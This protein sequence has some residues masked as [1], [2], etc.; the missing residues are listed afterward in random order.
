M[1]FSREMNDII[2]RLQLDDNGIVDWK[3]YDICRKLYHKEKIEFEDYNHMRNLSEKRKNELLEYIY[4]IQK[5]KSI[6]I[7]LHCYK[8]KD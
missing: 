4:V 5:N 8:N 1:P 7:Q 2:T 6:T 3:I